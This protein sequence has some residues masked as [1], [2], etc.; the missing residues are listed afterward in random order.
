MRGDFS[1]L[2]FRPEN[3]FTGVLLQQGRVQL[4][5]E[6]NE[7]VAIEA[8]RDREMTRDVVGPAGAPLDGGGF[9]VSVASMLRGVAAGD[10]AWAVGEAGTVLMSENGTEGWAFP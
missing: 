8:H 3:H 1:R 9:E 7:H 2:T 10:H 4:D 6:F 5:A